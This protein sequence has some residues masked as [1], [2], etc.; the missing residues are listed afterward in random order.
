MS[1][2]EQKT[3]ELL[4][5][6]TLS[7]SSVPP[8]DPVVT[9]NLMDGKSIMVGAQ[10]VPVKPVSANYNTWRYNATGQ[11]NNALNQGGLNQVKI[12]RGSGS[13][14]NIGPPYIRMHVFNNTGADV[15]MIP[16]PL[17]F[18]NIQCLTPDGG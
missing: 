10:Q 9:V 14:R 16:C 2:F 17:W 15:E 8:L 5:H 13:G 12:D 3:R 11:Y 6:V 1:D 4:T 7:P 18:Q